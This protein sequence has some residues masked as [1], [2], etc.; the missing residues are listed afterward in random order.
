MFLYLLRQT[1]EEKH[2]VSR[3]SA[4][5]D[6]CNTNY[7]SNYKPHVAVFETQQTHMIDTH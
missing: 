6:W 7:L 2:D 1:K 4:V 5:L 3:G